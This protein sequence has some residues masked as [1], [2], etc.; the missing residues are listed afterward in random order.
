MLSVFHAEKL[1]V[2]EKYQKIWIYS[3][4]SVVTTVILI[5][6]MLKIKNANALKQT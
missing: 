1:I 3:S 6:L 4:S 5:L 2:L